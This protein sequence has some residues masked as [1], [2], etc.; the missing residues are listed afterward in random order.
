MYIY[1]HT[2]IY[3]RN[4]KAHSHTQRLRSGFECDTVR[5]SWRTPNPAELLPASR[6]EVRGL[7]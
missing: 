4:P 3:R 7:G 6:F 1:I 5:C 2:Y